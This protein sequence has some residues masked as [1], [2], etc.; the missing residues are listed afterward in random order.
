MTDQFRPDH[1]DRP[2]ENGE[3]AQSHDHD[4]PA[5]DDA[6]PEA[7]DPGVPTPGV[8]LDAVPDGTEP[9]AAPVAESSTLPP[10]DEGGPL[11]VSSAYV[12]TGEAEAPT[13]PPADARPARRR[14]LP[15]V[16]R[17]ALLVYALL[18]VVLALGAWLRFDGAN[19][20]DYTHLHP[21]ERFLT[22]VVT[23]L[24]GPLNFTDASQA[25]RDAHRQRCE[26][27]Y[28]VSATSGDDFQ[29][30]LG[31][32]RGP[33]FDAECSPL[34]P[35]NV[36]AGLYV[37]GEF[38][39]FTVHA[40]GV[41]RSELSRDI[42]A[43]LEAYDADAA[44]EH[45]ITTHWEGYNG[46]HLVG[47]FISALADT[48]TILFVFLIG[49][50]LYGRWTGLLAAALYAVAGFPIQQAHFWTVDAFTTF[51]VVV[52]LYFA[53]RALDGAG[54]LRGP[55]PLLYLLVWAGGTAWDAAY[56]G[57]S[58]LGLLTL[59]AA[60]V[61]S[62]LLAYGVRLALRMMGRAGGDVVVA[63][64]G[65][66]ASVIYLAGW[67][68]LI[69][70]RLDGF[71]LDGK[72]LALGFVSL[73]YAATGLV[74]FIAA[75]IVR[76][77][78]LGAAIPQRQMLAV[79]AV[80]IVWIALAV[81]Y[82][83]GG[84]APW[85]A[86]FVAL[87]G[88][89]LLVADI[90]DLT[91]Y[92][93]FGAALGAAVA[94][95]VNVA[96][97]AG[98]IVVAAALRALPALDRRIHPHIR[99]RL[100][101]Y[102]GTGV[103]AA[104][105]ASFVVFRLLQPHAFQGPGI[106]GLAINPGW[107]E[108]VS[109]AAYF[110]SGDWDAPPNHQ[111]ADRT[112][113]F[114]PWRNIVLWGMGIP[115]GLVAWGAWLV[116]GIGMLRARRQWTRH[117]I[118]FLWT[119]VAFGW[120]G[121]RWVTTMRY[122]LPIYPTLI[123]LAAW[124]L[125]ALVRWA[126]RAWGGSQ[127]RRSRGSPRVR[128]AA[129]KRAAAAAAS[130]LL[131]GVL[132]YTTVYGFAVHNIHTHQ[133][134]R[135]AASRWFQETVPGDFG[136]WVE[137]DD[138]SRKMVNIGRGAVSAPPHVFHLPDGATTEIA[139][140]L[141]ADA[142]FDAL[143]FNLLGDPA[144]D[145]DAEVLRVRIVRDEPERGRQL[146]FEDTLEAD[147]NQADSPYGQSYTLRPDEAVELPATTGADQV[148]ANY[149]LEVTALEG[150]A[151]MSVRE[152]N[153][154]PVGALHDVRLDLRLAADDT[155]YALDLNFD[156]QP[157]IKGHGNDI[158][159]TPTHWSSTQAHTIAF[160]IPIDGEIRELAIP[161]L[162]DP[163]NDADA[164]TVH[165]T[166][167]GPDGATT[168]ATLRGDLS[169]QGDATL[170]PA[171]T[172]TF[173]PPLRVQRENAQGERLQATLTIEPEDMVYTSGPVI[174]WEG[175][176][177]DPVPWPTCPLPDDVEFRADLPSGLS[178]YN[179][180]SMNMYG[181]HYQGLKLWMVAED[182]EQKRTAIQNALDQADY[183]V[184][185]SNRFYDSL[186]R[187][188]WRWPMTMAY[189]HALFNGNLGFELVQTFESPPQIGPLRFDDQVLPTDDLPG[190]LNEHWEAE[191]AFHVYDHPV[192]FVFAKTGAYS[193]EN[194]HAV[195]TSESL[196]PVTS[197]VPGYV[198]DS[199]PVGV[200]VQGA[201]EAS[202]APTL[203]HLTDSKWQLQQAG[204]TWSDLFDLG[205]LLNRSQIAAVLAWWVLIV[206]AG[207]IAWPLLFASLPALPDRGFP[208]A[209]ITAWLIVAWVA[210][211]GGTLNLPAWSRGGLALI[212]LGLAALSLLV[213]WRRRVAFVTYIRAN[214]R[215]LLAVE[216][217]A[218]VLY[219]AFLGVRQGNPD[220]WHNAFGGEKPMDFAYFNAVLRSSVF[221]P[222]D[223]WFAGGYINYYYWGYVLVG[224]P[225]KLLGIRPSL[226][227]NL[228]IPALY[229]MTGLGVFTIA[230]NWVRSR[231]GHHGALDVTRDGGAVHV[232][233]DSAEPGMGPGDAAL[234]PPDEA[235][236]SDPRRGRLPL[237]NP[238]VAGLLALVLA[239]VLGNLGTVRVFVTNVARLDEGGYAQ[240]A[241]FHQVRQQEAEARRSEIYQEFYAEELDRFRD[242]HDGREP[243][244]TE[245]MVSVTQAVQART[246]AYIEDYANH[247]PLWELWKYE[248]EN[249]LDTLASFFGGLD[250]LL[251]GRE[252]P[253]A[254]HRWYW[255]PTRIISE[256]PSGAGNNAIAE[257]PYF[258]FLY[259]DLH[260]HM[261]AFPITLL[262]MLWLLAEI[263]GAGRGL[264]RWW[265]AALALGIGALA[266][267]VLRPTNSW[268]WITYLLLGIAGL[269]YVAWLDAA[270]RAEG[271][272][273]AFEH[274]WG[275]LRPGRVRELWWLLLAAP[276]GLLARVAFY[277]MQRVQADEQAAR[278]LKPGETLIDPTLTLSGALLWAVLALAVAV[279]VYGALL[280]AFRAHADR[281][282][283]VGWVG[284]V[285]GFLALTF[286]AALPFTAYFATAYTSVKPWDR[287][288]TPLWAYMYVHGTFIFIV[289]AF[290]VWQSAR[291]LRHVTVRDLRGQAVP[292]IVVVGLLLVAVAGGIVYG[293]REA[294]I[295][296]L[297]VPLAAW[298]ALLFFLPGQHRLLR[299]MYALI[300]LA[301]AI[302]LG[303]ELVV[304]E[305]DIGRQNTVFKFYLQVWFIL[306]IVGGV[307]L[308]WM[309][310]V[311]YRWRLSLRVLW[312]GG[313]AILFAIALL[314]P[315]LATQARFLDRFAPEKT[316]LTLDGMDYMQYAV[317]GEHEL[318]FPLRGDY[319][320]IRWLQ[321]N[322]E[323][324]P[325]VAEAHLYP[326][327]YHWGGRI[328]IYTGLPTVL[329]WRFHQLQQHSLDPLNLLV[330]TRENNVAAFYE[331][332]GE[333]GIRTA[334][335]LADHYDIQYI[336]VGALE[337]AFYGD[338]ATDPETLRQ[339]AGHSEGLAKFETMVEQDLLAVVFRA[340]RCL[341]YGTPV[342][343][344]SP[345]QVYYDTI[346]R[347]VPDTQASPPSA[348]APVRP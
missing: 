193:P 133:L 227:Y 195:L 213:I 228:I 261:L 171:Q 201:K 271:P 184:I 229:S 140:T 158:P 298:A 145:L 289:V 13:A 274:L 339:T 266:V 119:L 117:A 33:Y 222:L 251:A 329:G 311:A 120:L 160:D 245:E 143:T 18:L 208:A 235:T 258:T 323:G 303:V 20:D 224:A 187:I 29:S 233:P 159:S 272:A 302:S 152:M 10:A 198:A 299:A 248:L 252:L 52:A 113:Y 114:Y 300:V 288:T 71:T 128:V 84:L 265:E 138:G 232:A 67:A 332:P 219:V 103:L 108:D 215:Y 58:V 28:P 341:E 149:T 102:A 292:V 281:R 116:A 294:A 314:Y 283:L 262:A 189:Y 169:A 225:V 36:G 14:V 2:P 330:Q 177:D 236:E 183:I 62:L 167:T 165:F 199:E 301:L 100:V 35:N 142:T 83:A 331:I 22:D 46:A 164:E 253:M 244:T 324:T 290:L 38:P 50:R 315:V 49:R 234:L 192:V 42:H 81:G 318:W 110:T 5:Q 249:N 287:E 312:L 191:E 154:P 123:L 223:P 320:M 101:F 68:A 263:I 41:A 23:K 326:S 176:W 328:S 345:D 161:H 178:S 121:G 17:A 282:A 348:A 7:A 157:L 150:G 182:N 347:F 40:A 127:P 1:D 11:R 79:G 260:A 56:S 9:D 237:G 280:I 129:R 151:V 186:S 241:L 66:F 112:P 202:K 37:Y 273:P 72:V 141:P 99:A 322:V 146:L 92:V 308:A 55:V 132:G 334:L 284:R 30:L 125:V 259:G 27:R 53:V 39:L 216:A 242:E 57:Y 51:W 8:P 335:S 109:D 306:S 317:H 310:Q 48:L 34:N 175:D 76:Q 346:Y 255:A 203:L 214:W 286:V 206:L 115:L 25:E 246:D 139:F 221:P 147:L 333:D 181:S 98:I 209:K 85:S 197:A 45:T 32:G 205:A 162:G 268:D 80:G 134:T 106:F 87:V 325:V 19:W 136:I 90:T 170:G 190:W 316:P 65:V 75:G 156:H 188:P 270:R 336:V 47:R 293:V 343:A 95:R 16:D 212:L 340:P 26:E 277:A 86:L 82:I 207:W 256:L 12:A 327:E 342:E 131:I 122:F 285:G 297:V 97:L 3:N 61:F 104:A 130:V 210:W 31:A 21:D 204:G 148:T 243:Q 105:L 137:G 220:L 70:L 153:D 217:L 74:A 337:R 59:G 196:R 319:E 155:P 338:I 264:R 63:A 305:G 163:L 296:Q 77:H 96:P 6:A 60:F 240:P 309:L 291:W 4:V 179:C 230:Y 111:W 238:W 118:P 93:L 166:L 24:N 295:A 54:A 321:D 64:S 88:V 180:A 247:P 174:A 304:L 257:M 168:S 226:A 267:G 276:L 250:A 211:V 89:A 15:R 194:T 172:V 231:A 73:V 126:W 69:A 144:R 275:R 173:D 91:D 124:A 43:F 78:V 218:L 44:A 107:R 185:T 344:C 200:V 254:T 94:G 307:A 239:L 269:T 135:V 278:G 279:A 313:L